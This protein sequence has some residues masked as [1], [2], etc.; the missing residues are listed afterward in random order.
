MSTVAEPKAALQYEMLAPED[1][2]ELETLDPPIGPIP[3]PG[4]SAACV[5]RDQG[6]LI[7]VMFLQMVFHMEPLYIREN[8]RGS[9]SFLR[10]SRVLEQ[11]LLDAI[12]P[13]HVSGYYVFSPNAK[14]GKMCK[15][16]GMTQHTDWKV[17]QKVIKKEKE[18]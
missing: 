18:E 4:L 8:K 11:S 15:L 5:V 10:M 12:P 17:W 3:H 14:I 2:K 16:G 6:E 1:W 9:V 7:A 13:G